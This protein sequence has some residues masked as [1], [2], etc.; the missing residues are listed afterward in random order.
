VHVKKLLNKKNLLQVGLELIYP[1]RM[2]AVLLLTQKPKIDYIKS[3]I[4]H[5][6][7]R[8]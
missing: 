1:E 5:K 7:Y 8:N 3:I 4:G 2:A 6:K